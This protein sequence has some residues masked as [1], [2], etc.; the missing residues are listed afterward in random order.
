MPKQH[1]CQIFPVVKIN[2]ATEMNNKM[3]KKGKRKN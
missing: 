1:K 2:D 3:K